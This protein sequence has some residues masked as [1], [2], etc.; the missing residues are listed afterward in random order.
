MFI[1]TAAGKYWDGSSWTFDF[2]KAKHYENI[3]DLPRILEYSSVLSDSKVVVDK[4]NL[5][6][7]TYSEDDCFE[8]TAVV[9]GLD[10]LTLNLFDGDD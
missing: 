1:V 9:G 4:L 6:D 8:I 5:A 2:N 3:E 10:N 7:L